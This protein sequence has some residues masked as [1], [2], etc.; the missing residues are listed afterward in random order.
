MEPNSTALNPKRPRPKR[1]FL[2]HSLLNSDSNSESE[3]VPIQTAVTTQS[4]VAANVGQ[5]LLNPPVPITMDSIISSM[6]RAERSRL[7]GR[8]GLRLGPRSSRGRRHSSEVVRKLKEW[9]LAHKSKPYPNVDEKS[10]LCLSTD[11]D[12]QQV[13]DWFA[14]ARRTYKTRHNN[15]HNCDNPC[16]ME[17]QFLLNFTF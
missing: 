11:L 1:S 13:D 14:N 3:N 9:F 17:C 6:S 15:Y 10:E 5:Q 7:G 16:N 8:L 4:N 12:R 2:M